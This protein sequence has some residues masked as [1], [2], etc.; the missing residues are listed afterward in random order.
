MS[1]INQSIADYLNEMEL[2]SA[3]RCDCARRE[4]EAMKTLYIELNIDKPSNIH[5]IF[6]KHDFEDFR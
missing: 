6:E 1:N 3:L 5:P 4:I 2:I